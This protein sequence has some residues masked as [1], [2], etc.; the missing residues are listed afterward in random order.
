MSHQWLHC[1]AAQLEALYLMS[2]GSVRRLRGQGE[3]DADDFRTDCAGNPEASFFD[4]PSLSDL[5]KQVTTNRI[6]RQIDE[7]FGAEDAAPHTAGEALHGGACDGS[8]SPDDP[9]PVQD[10][11]VNA[12]RQ[13]KR[14]ARRC[15]AAVAAAE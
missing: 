15:L 8:V 6:L 9:T 3:G 11:V 5:L 2:I 13:A 4:R 7:A 10:L 14:H 1:G 12:A